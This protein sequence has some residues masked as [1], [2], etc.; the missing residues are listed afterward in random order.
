VDEDAA[1]TAVAGAVDA[2]AAPGE[3]GGSDPQPTRA[4]QRARNRSRPRKVVFRPVPQNVLISVDGAEPKP[5]GPSF[6]Q[7]KLS[8]GV[9]RFR[10]IGGAECCKPEEF[11]RRIPPGPGRTVLSPELEFRPARIYVV[12]NVPADVVIDHGRVEGRTRDVLRVPMDGFDDVVDVSVTAPG[13]EDYTGE[14][15]LRAGKLV[16]PPEITLEASESSR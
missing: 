9:H 7:V 4:A 8:P 11:R 16:Q 14:V 5:F 6:R 13:Y 1:A 15:R 3:S 2:D 12:A 10:F